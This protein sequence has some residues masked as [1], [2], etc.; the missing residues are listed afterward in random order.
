MGYASESVALGHC[1]S[2]RRH[3]T[4]GLTVVSAG[5]LALGLVVAPPDVRGVRTEVRQVQLTTFALSA[6]ALL[7]ALEKLIATRADTVVPVAKA[8]AGGAA[9]I[10][11]AVGKTPTAGESTP[12]TFGAATD[13][14]TNPHSVDVAALAPTTTAL[15]IPA[16]LLAAIPEPILAI[17][18]IA[19]LFGP[20][21][22]LVILACPPC[23]LFNFL[24]FTIPS[25][26]IPFAPLSA[27]AEV[28]TASVEA[29]A[30]APTLASDPELSNSAPGSATT[31]GPADGARPGKIGKPDPSPQVTST[32]PATENES[33]STDTTTSTK[34][35]TETAKPD[36]ES[37]VP[38][39]GS[40][41]GP[42][43]NDSEPEATKPTVRR[44]TPRIVVRDSLGVGEQ[45]RGLPHRGKGGHPTTETGAAGDGAAT[46]GPSSTAGNSTA[47]NSSGG[48]S[49]DS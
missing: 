3:L 38:A 34:D 31:G 22:L 8:A 42:S 20:I 10:P 48:D 21:I 30:T 37:T 11:A 24:T 43:A 46:A 4:T 32:E 2:V 18:G 40:A 19:L 26:F 6:P 5:I 29:I 41:P 12:P 47:G 14:A 13:P 44:A 39:A 25:L 49:D 1:P 45:L 35:R 27:V 9:D 23:A 15:E 16:P 28:S 7:G 36:E 33:L 17:V